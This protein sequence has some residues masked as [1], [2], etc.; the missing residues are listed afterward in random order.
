MTVACLG[1]RETLT[2]PNGNV[3]TWVYDDLN[4]VEREIDPLLNQTLFEY[5]LN[6]NRTQQTD[7]NG[8]VT[9]Y[10]YDNYNRLTTEYTGRITV[11]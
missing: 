1:N 8:R 4:R 11:P 10:T 5:D 2:D 3:T 7:R 9:Q 6:G